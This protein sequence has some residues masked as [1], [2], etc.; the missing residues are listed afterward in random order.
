MRLSRPRAVRAVGLAAVAVVGAAVALLAIRPWAASRGTVP[1]PPGE[2]IPLPAPRLEGA[3]SVEEALAA[4]RSLRSFG[5]EPLSL[6]EVGQLL[7][8]AQGVT[9]ARGYRTAPSAGALYPLEVYLVCRRVEELEPGVYRYLPSDHALSAVA[10]ASRGGDACEALARAALG[11][12][13]VRDAAANVVFAGV[14]ERTTA[15]YGY[16]GHQYVH[17]EV[18]HA[19]ENVYLQATALGLATVAV[20]AFDDAEVA[21]VLLLPEGETPLYVMPVGRPAT[22]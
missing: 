17:I 2:P 19:A 22:E 4:R 11:Q 10:A 8:A 3:I 13:P 14:Y 18:G 16:R 12:S 20:G 6:Q 15:K 1:A 7:W 5:S 21:Q 9:D